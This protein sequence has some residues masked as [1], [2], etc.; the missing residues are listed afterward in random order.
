MN[1]NDLVWNASLTRS[2]CKGKFTLKAEAFD[3]LHQLSSTQYAV[4]AQARTETWRNTIPSYCMMHV[5]YKFT[6]K[7]KNNK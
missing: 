7:P 5:S 2:F 3:L 1:T 4:N 6:K